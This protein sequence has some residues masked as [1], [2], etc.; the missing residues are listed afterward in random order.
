LFDIVG[1]AVLGLVGATETKPVVGRISSSLKRDLHVDE[2]VVIGAPL[3]TDLGNV[4]I[5]DDTTTGHA[6]FFG[7]P[8]LSCEVP[9]AVVVR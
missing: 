1:A 3:V 8:L 7:N 9:E 4:M 6:S 2:A 5:S